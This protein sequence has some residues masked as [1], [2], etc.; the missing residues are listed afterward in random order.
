[1]KKLTVLIM[2][3]LLPVLKPQSTDP[4]V[5]A[6]MIVFNAKITTQNLAQPEA[7]AVA[8]KRGR[9][10]AVGS[11]AEIL[12]L[13]H[14]DTK[15]I[16]AD[17]RRL[18]PGLNDAHTHVLNERGYNY[19]LRWDGVPTLKRALEMLSEQAK[20]TPE[21]HWV[22]VIGGWSPH[23][24]KERRLPTMQ[25]LNNAVPNRP[26]IV[27]YAY[28][29]AF[30]NDQA[31]RAFGVGTSRFP[32][33][34]GTVFEKD[35]R[36]RYTGVMSANT[37]MFVTMEGLVPQPSF[38]EQKSSL[39]Q[40]INDMNGFGVTT[41]VDAGA[42]EGYPQGH[43]PLRALMQDNLLNIRFSFLDL[44]FSAPPVV[45]EIEHIT[46]WDP[47]S[48]GQNRH[49]GMEH[50]YEYEGMGEL[51]RIAL[52]DHEDFDKPAV[53][54]NTDSMH[55]YIREDIGKLVRRR[56]PFRMHN[57]YNE[58]ITHFL[59]ALEAIN[60]ETPFE[61]LRWAVEHAE[62]ISPENMD[63][64]KRLGGG[65]AFEGKMA[66]HGDGFMKTYS[67]EEALQTPPFRL[68]LQKGVPLGLSTDGFRASSYNP[69]TTIA[70]AVTGKSV[71]GSTV[72]GES[73]RLTRAEALRLFTIGSAWF[74]HAEHE[75]GR[76]APANL[77]DFAL[78]DA[79]YFTVP[80]EEI[81]NISSVLT[82]VG[83]RV[84]FGTGEYSSLAPKLPEIIPAWS[85]IKHFGGYYNAN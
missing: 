81:K 41:A 15:L 34:P 7:S 67:R 44:Q 71:S 60:R 27:Q 52:H 17:G 57:T 53:I 20:R 42:L 54:I 68:M 59:D 6:D 65:V 38:E 58:N 83:G 22:K 35:S 72:L 9:I 82:V 30:L 14:N 13:K 36:G 16:D 24:F 75:M 46:K 77:A 10:Y 43:G 21:G 47:T 56:I 25:E 73:N 66:L 23:Q 49:P 5:G 29:Q 84:V 4:F 18:I 74:E 76:I 37:L 28:N 19:A 48:P 39:A 12:T 64:V 69:W 51:I 61:G 70:W 8:V 50:G 45:G 2:A 85:P 33:L 32:M 55:Q 40:A 26:F 3:A 78:L 79:D 63:R 11:D 31:I 62:F 80:D 1:M